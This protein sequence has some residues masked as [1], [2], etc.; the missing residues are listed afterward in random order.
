MENKNRPE[1][2]FRVGAVCASIWHRLNTR[3]TGEQYETRQVTVD[4]SYKDL[5]GEWKSSTSL[6]VNDVPKA[7]LAL[8]RA[9][10]YMIEGP[11]RGISPSPIIHEE[12]VEV[13][14]AQA[15]TAEPY[16]AQIAPHQR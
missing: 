1:K 13:S 11:E 12:L 6:D 4:R 14:P 15:Q 7:I 10:P 8:Q 5:R 3:K 16:Q 2:K 9:Y